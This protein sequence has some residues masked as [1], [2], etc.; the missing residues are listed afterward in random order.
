MSDNG[1]D[2]TQPNLYA[3]PVT[4][5]D[6]A[7]I[8]LGLAASYK[9]AVKVNDLEL[10]GQVHELIGRVKHAFEQM[11]SELIDTSDM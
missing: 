4:R 2:D 5:R 9:A 3:F 6:M 7:A 10:A 1:R 8:G 11:P